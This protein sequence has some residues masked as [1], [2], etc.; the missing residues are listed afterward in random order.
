MRRYLVGCLAVGPLLALVAGPR[1]PSSVVASGSSTA[2]TEH[3]LTPARTA[4]P[5]VL[6]RVGALPLSF[7]ENRGQTDPRVA[8]SVH[9]GDTSVFL[10]REGVVFAL[11]PRGDPATGGGRCA[12]TSRAPTPTW[13]WPGTVEAT[14]S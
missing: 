12:S 5:E 2:P 3:R 13:R 10:T 7:V 6:E 9:G 4:S 1:V 11:S 8:Y 14:R